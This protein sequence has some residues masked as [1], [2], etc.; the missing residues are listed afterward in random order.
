MKKIDKDLLEDFIYIIKQDHDVYS[1]SGRGMFNKKCLAFTIS[2]EDSKAECIADIM[3]NFMGSLARKI[4]A[5]NFNPDSLIDI[6]NLFH[7]TKMDSMGMDTVMY[8]PAI[9]WQDQWNEED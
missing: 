6:A 7:G 3:A 8:F 2:R 1:Y 9:E 4:D 5:E